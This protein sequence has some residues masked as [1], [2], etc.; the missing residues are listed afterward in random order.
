MKPKYNSFKK[1]AVCWYLGIVKHEKNNS[2]KKNHLIQ[3][4]SLGGMV[5]YDVCCIDSC[6]I[7][8][9]SS[10]VCITSMALYLFCTVTMWLSRISLFVLC[11]PRSSLMF[12][13]VRCHNNVLIYF[14]KFILMLTCSNYSL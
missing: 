14:S 13:G 2:L 11:N 7:F 9:C 3:I 8:H 12:H 10:V 4:L 1:H 6:N 5:S